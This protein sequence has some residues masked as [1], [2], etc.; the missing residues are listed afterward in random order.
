VQWASPDDTNTL[1]NFSD[2]C[3]GRFAPACDRPSRLM[4]EA[5]N[6]GLCGLSVKP[7]SS[8][9][10]QSRALGSR[11]LCAGLPMYSVTRYSFIVAGVVTLELCVV[12]DVPLNLPTYCTT[13]AAGVGV[14][15]KIFTSCVAQRKKNALVQSTL[16][17]A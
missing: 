3:A 14:A 4:F 13:V 7:A 17:R 11:L 2:F 15:L 10:R 9:G 6:D 16:T 12:L 8:P 1:R 5:G